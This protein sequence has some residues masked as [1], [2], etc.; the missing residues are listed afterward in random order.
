VDKN[1][2]TIIIVIEHR[3]IMERLS[4]HQF[5]FKCFGLMVMKA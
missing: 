1:E 2:E 4:P 3:I 5:Y